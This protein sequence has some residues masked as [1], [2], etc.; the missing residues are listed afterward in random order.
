MNSRVEPTAQG[1]RR[2]EE[3]V[4]SRSRKRRVELTTKAHDL[5]EIFE[6]IHGGEGADDD[7]PWGEAF[8]HTS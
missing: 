8:C 4:H 5:I 1:L 3:D 2:R 6:R 7:L